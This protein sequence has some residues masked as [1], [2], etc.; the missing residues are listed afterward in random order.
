MNAVPEILKERI[1]AKLAE[2]NVTAREISVAV[3]HPDIIRNIKRG[4]MPSASRLDAIAA[5][6]GTTA[7]WLL[8]RDTA[9]E[10]TFPADTI[11]SD[12]LRRLPKTLPIYG[13]ALGADVQFSYDGGI[14]VVVEQTEVHMAAPLDFMARP[15]GVTGRPDLYV[16]EVSGHSMEPRHEPG[17]R[18]LVDPRRAP[19]I[20][21]DVIVQLRGP[22]FDGE[23][24]RHVLIKQLVK[25]RPGVVVLRQFNPM[26]IFEVPNEQVAAVHRVMPWDEALGF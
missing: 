6:L 14:T 18:L 16:V 11:N 15:I 5:E 25:R 17:R 19:G 13:T 20:G 1:E 21:E 9:I 26:A 7:E 12:A 4:N 3:G 24:V 10:R 23:E 8:G 2:R 22:T